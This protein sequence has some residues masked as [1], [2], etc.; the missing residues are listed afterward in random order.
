MKQL[1]GKSGTFDGIGRRGF[2]LSS[3]AFGAAATSAWPGRVLSAENRVLR[4]RL[5]NDINRLDPAIYENAYNVDVM[6]CIYPKLVTYKPNSGKWDWQLEAAEAIEQIDDTHIRFK[7]RPGIMWSDGY[8]EVTA[9]DVKY[10]FE[11]VI[12][13]AIDSPVKGDWG[14]L[15]HVE[16]ED[17]YS[18]VIVLNEPFQ[19]LWTIA[20]PYGVGHIVCKAAVEKRGGGSFGM[21]STAFAGPFKLKEWR[22]NEVTV[23]ERNEA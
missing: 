3:L 4:A 22:A 2:M 12:D 18:G 13:P 21:E 5:Y 19:P 6:N 8:G 10:S 9:E 14:P 1:L 15:S 16:I 7:L 20:L 23:L 17:T 11:R